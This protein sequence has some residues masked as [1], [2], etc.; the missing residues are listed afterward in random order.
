MIIY[1]TRTI[2]HLFHARLEI[3]SKAPADIHQ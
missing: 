1:E 2:Q 3:Y